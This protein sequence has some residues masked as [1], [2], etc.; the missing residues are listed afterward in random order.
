MTM[1]GSQY[2]LENRWLTAEGIAGV[3]YR[4][5][6]QVR[7]KSGEHSGEIAEVIALIS[8]EP[9]PVY[10]VVLPPNEESVL[11]PQQA[12]EATGRNAGRTLRSHKL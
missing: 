7:I 10:V 12:L 5:S 1:P 2:E 8:V 9:E 4:F 11:L 3:N 6:D